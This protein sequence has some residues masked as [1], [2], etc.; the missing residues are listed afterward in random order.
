MPNLKHW[1]DRQR[2]ATFTSIVLREAQVPVGNLIR[3][4]GIIV[5]A[6]TK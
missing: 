4:E 3:E 5:M 1:L 2:P 6:G